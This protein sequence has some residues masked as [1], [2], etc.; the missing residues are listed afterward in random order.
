MPLFKDKWWYSTGLILI[1]SLFSFLLIPAI[2]AIALYIIQ[3]INRKKVISILR[4]D[5]LVNTPIKEKQ[6]M[7]LELGRRIE[8]K[9]TELEEKNTILSDKNALIQNVIKETEDSIRIENKATIEDAELQAKRIVEEANESLRAVV[10][11]TAEYQSNISGLTVEYEALEKEVN[12]YK[13]QARK[14]KSEVTGLKNFDQR[15]PHTINFEK[16]ESSIQEIEDTLNKDSLLGTVIRLYLHS[17]NSKELRSLSNATNK[18]IKNVLEK[19]ED[20]YTTK[21]NKTIYSLMIIGLQAEMQLLLFQLRYNKLE[22]SV[23]SVKDIITKYLAICGNG[24]QAILPTITKFL[25]EI[26]PLYVELLNIEY[27]YYVYREREKEE[28]RLIKEQMKQEALERKQLAEERKKLEKE[29]QKFEIEMNR[30]KELLELETDQE[31]IQQLLDRLTE[32]ESQM[33]NINDKKEEIASLSLGKAGYVYVIS[34]LGSFG[35]EM[36]KIGMTRRMVPQDRIDELGDASVPFKFD[37]HAMIFS[38]DA[39]GLEQKLHSILNE[40]RVNKVNYRKEFFKTNLDSLREIVEEI[41]PTV[42]FVTTMLAEE[43]N[44]TLSIENSVVA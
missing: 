35:D 4:E 44:Q 34:N 22:E 26:E 33:K 40:R 8:E 18:E 3:L 20:R 23:Q 7:L 17:D 2:V 5:E 37:V 24:N 10:E 21:G 27:K 6:E 14:F 15:F 16:V 30:N 19:Y 32:L 31:K 28:Q 13:K 29:E 1:L 43:Y 38:D 9:N 41:D 42:E 25:T 36:F 11:K 39:V 12:R